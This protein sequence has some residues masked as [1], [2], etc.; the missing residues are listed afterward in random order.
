MEDRSGIPKVWIHTP[1]QP[2]YSLE[3]DISSKINT[4]PSILKL[5]FD[6]FSDPTKFVEIVKRN[7]GIDQNKG[8]IHFNGQAN[9]DSFNLFALHLDV[10]GKRVYKKYLRL[11][12]NFIRTFLGDA[13]V[14]IEFKDQSEPDLPNFDELFNTRLED[15]NENVK[16]AFAADV[17][18][19]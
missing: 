1:G 11:N 5:H 17:K 9:S 2:D 3:F 10:S 13:E 16:H 15:F 18:V 4:Y 7:L 12:C 19:S 6:D 8:F 14:S